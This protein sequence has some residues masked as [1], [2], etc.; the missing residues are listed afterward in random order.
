[1][2]YAVCFGYNVNIIK[3]NFLFQLT[4]SK[5]IGYVWYLQIWFYWTLP[6]AQNHD[7]QKLL[8]ALLWHGL[9]KITSEKFTQTPCTCKQGN[10]NTM[11]LKTLHGICSSQCHP[12]WWYHTDKVVGC[13]GIRL[14][15]RIRT[16]REWPWPFENLT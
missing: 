16:S 7:P 14:V 10:A 5:H 9:I 8:Q 2:W 13:A 4:V 11:T 15:I 6:D 3:I 1:M 12:R